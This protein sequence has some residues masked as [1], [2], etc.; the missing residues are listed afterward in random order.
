MPDTFHKHATTPTLEK[1]QD[2]IPFF[3]QA[4]HFLTFHV[5]DK[6]IYPQWLQ[7]VRAVKGFAAELSDEAVCVCGVDYTLWRA[8]A[9]K[10][11][12]PMPEQ[13]MDAGVLNQVPFKNTE[14][15]F[16][17]HI[18]SESN[19]TCETIAEFV[20]A[21]FDGLAEHHTET[22]A[23]KRPQGKVI[24]KRFRDAMI[25]P[26]DPVNFAQRI[27]V[28][29][30]DAEYEGSSFVIQQK[31]QHSWQRLDAMTMIEKENMIGRDHDQVIIPQ[32]DE[33]SHIK[34]V[35]QLDGQRVTQRILRQAIPYGHAPEG[36]GREEGIYFVAY[37]NAP[38]VFE[39]LVKNI[40]G[41]EPGFVKD[42]LLANS[43]AVSG[44][45][46]F[47]PSTRWIEMPPNDRDARVPLNDYFDVRSDNGLMYY[48]NRDFLHKAQEA[49][50]DGD[51]ISDRI[52]GL[53]GQT[54]MQR[55][56]TWTKKVTMAPLGKLADYTSDPAFR[57]GS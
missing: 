3:P 31:F 1:S 45:M 38:E 55:N 43:H 22:P 23:H 42:A 12:L 46:W 52:M 54:F 10:F 16:W 26:V 7:I 36:G 49:N 8:W 50:A 48:N 44:N 24:G 19:E 32:H 6:M 17:F 30:E 29:A 41:D 14:G 57:V 56:D 53:L 4:A 21:Q 9:E 33:R 20:K 40:V 13:S 37:S 25:N 34:C 39:D 5:T 28:G 11:G 15:D 27:L 18:K 2:G 35:R 47:V 51:P